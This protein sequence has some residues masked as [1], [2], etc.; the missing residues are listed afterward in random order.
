M[1]GSD[2]MMDDNGDKG[3]FLNMVVATYKDFYDQV[4]MCFSAEGKPHVLLV[5]TYLWLWWTTCMDVEATNDSL[6]PGDTLDATEELCSDNGKYCLNFS[7]T[8]DDED[9]AYLQI[10][11]QKDD[12]AVWVANRN[13]PVDSN[14]AVLSLNYSGVLKIE[15]QRGKPIILYSPPQAIN[16]T[17]AT[18]L[19][20]GNFVLQQLHPNGSTTGVL[21]ESFDL[22]TDTLLPGM[23]LGVNHKTGRNWSLVSWLSKHVLT[24]GPFRLEWEPNTR[25]LI[26]KRGERVYWASGN[27]FEHISGEAQHE[28]VSNETGDYFILKKSKEELT[29]WTLLS[30]GQMINRNGGDVARADRCYGCNTDEGCQKW[31]EIP[32]CR[33]HGDV[34]QNVQGYL[35]PE[36]TSDETNSS[37][38]IN[39]CQAICWSNCSCVGFTYYHEN[40]TGCTFLWDSMKGTNTASEGDQFYVLR[41]SNRHKQ[42]KTKR[43]EIEKQEVAASSKS[44]NKLE[45]DLKEE[46][47][48]KV[49]SYASLMEATNGF[50]SGNKLGQGGFG[51]VYKGILSTRQEVAVKTLSK[52][53]GQGL[54][55][56]KNELTL[57]SKLQH[58]NLV[59]L[60]GYCIHEEERILIYEYMP[61]RSLD[62]ILFDSTQ[63]QLLDWNKRF[64]IIEGI[65]Q[66]LLYLHKYSRL[67]IIHRDLKASNILLDENM[68]PKI[69]DFG[70]AKMFTQQDS[71]ANTSRIVGTYGYMS[72]EYAMEG[73]FSTKSD[74]YSF[75]VLLFEIVSGKRNNSVYTEERPLNLVGHAWELWKKGEPLKVV[76]LALND[77]FS[78][79][80][81]LR[82]V[83]AGLLCV[84]ENADDRPSMSNIVSMLTNKSKVTS[85]PKKPAYYL[86][87]KVLGEETSTKEFGVDY[88]HENSLSYVC[89]I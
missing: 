12:W 20:T 60:L 39:D 30:T 61:N 44:S 70:T 67:R 2:L 1:K 47:D 24:P 11:S 68:N 38:S 22:P 46:H 78:E 9:V 32:H 72:P 75:G 63:S 21:W 49:F 27:E 82:C 83:H 80:E 17:V 57:I 16:N 10:F 14:S 55:E 73:V 26:I 62:F 15:S 88:I 40:E 85:L 76:D 54:I 69:S 37:Y 86:R 28:I 6:K 50:S 5:L 71:E 66:G 81:V 43:M 77:S 89:S 58:T 19:D 35:N 31:E 41:R 59:Q 56:F 84:E 3:R 36:M 25:Q 29:K 42:N 13:Q 87:T 18:L 65:A 48:L 45:F 51:L 7:Q 52:S 74:V 23:K 64:L 4:R 79:D 53:S 8:F 34:F 33:N